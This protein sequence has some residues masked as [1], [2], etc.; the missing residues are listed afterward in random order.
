MNTSIYCYQPLFNTP[1]DR[2]IQVCDD[3]SPRK[4]G[5]VVTNDGTVTVAKW[6]TV[7]LEDEGQYWCEAE[8]G[9]TGTLTS[10]SA[11]LYVRGGFTGTRDSVV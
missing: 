2:L 1:D 7:E 3:E 11:T 9:E 6:E 4:A 10:S 5:P 8:F